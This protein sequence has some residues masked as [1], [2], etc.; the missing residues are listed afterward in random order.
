VGH[1][2]PKF[3]YISW[4]NK[5]VKAIEIFGMDYRI[6]EETGLTI[7]IGESFLADF[8]VKRIESMLRGKQ[9]E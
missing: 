4:S 5:V 1:T 3:R 2:Y 6:E 8:A 9:E 7:L